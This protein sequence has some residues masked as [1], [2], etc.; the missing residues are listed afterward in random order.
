GAIVIIAVSGMV[1]VAK[2]RRLFRLRRIDFALALVA[3]LAVLTFETLQALLVSVVVS[4][5]ALVWRTSQPRLAVLGRVP[6]GLDFSDLNRHPA[7][8]AVPGLLMVR[9]ENEMFFANA[10]GLR[11][12]IMAE[13]TASP[14][15]VV[16]VVVD[17]SATT[18]LDVPGADALGELHEQLH[19][20]GIRLMLTHVIA[21]VGETLDRAGHVEDLHV[22]D[23]FVG[24]VE[25]VLDHLTQHGDA[26]AINGLLDGAEASAS[27]IRA[28]PTAAG[29]DTP[30]GS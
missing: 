28:T 23:V 3:L 20:R 6:D 9:P 24:P 12:A 29:T 30:A 4:L 2:L 22:G 14:T 11:E 5:F 17:L 7:N 15:P 25:A 16:A 1:K 27:R 18:D 21:S 26:G 19:E 10:A 13:V 8:V